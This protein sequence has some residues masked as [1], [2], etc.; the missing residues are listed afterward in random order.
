M[1]KQKLE[2]V[3]KDHGS[4]KK[5][6]NWLCLFHEDHNPSAWIYEKDGKA[7]LVCGVC[8]MI[9]DWNDVEDRLSGVKGE[10][11]K[12]QHKRSKEPVK[13]QR[14]YS[15]K[16]IEDGG[17]ATK[18]YSEDRKTTYC[19]T[20]RY[21]Q[22]K[23]ERR[24]AIFS[25]NGGGFIAQA[26]NP[27]PIL[28]LP[29][30]RNT[31]E[32]VICE[33]EKCVKALHKVGI[34]AT[35]KPCGGQAPEKADWTPVHGK[36]VILWPDYDAKGIGYMEQVKDLL[37]PHCR[38][39]WID[40]TKYNL[41]PK[42]D[43]YDYCVAIKWDKLK[44]QIPLT[45]AV[46]CGVSRGI[47][48]YVEDVISGKLYPVEWP[49]KQLTR[50]S[51]CLTPGS[52]TLF[53]GGGGAGKSM[54]LINAMMYWQEENIKWCLHALESPMKNHMLRALAIKTQNSEIPDMDWIIDNPEEIRGCLDEN[55]D[56]IDAF[57][58][59]ITVA[60]SRQTQTQIGKWI[61]EKAKCGHRIV[62]IDPISIVKADMGNNIWDA[63]DAFVE[64]LEKIA[65]EHG[66]SIVTVIHPTKDE[67]AP[68]LRAIKGGTAWPNFTHTVLWLEPIKE[69]ELV[70]LTSVGR[71]EYM[72][73][74]K[75]HLFKTREGR[76]WNISLGFWFDK[77][78]LKFTEHGMIVK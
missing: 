33:G 13:K 73:N 61:V 10:S 41:P 18:Y 16:E 66:I 36:E 19:I 44:A 78:T 69:K 32:V 43:A 68:S 14:I 30:V 70:C 52:T 4:F 25:P 75:L 49:W 57:G 21:E 5:N 59:N 15:L 71:T 7:R 46:D 77:N 31:K 67:G 20:V 1:S 51:R 56:W 76:E 37:L 8:G 62:V 45:E 58:R 22:G 50:L 35:T 40:P 24:F 47:S 74:R 9:G 27:L 11:F 29:S 17:E 12:K 2:Q 55:K 72:V 39:R 63:D 34:V 65:T 54:F 53:C 38:V 64:L 6:T 60:K 42:G 26:P 3:L 23:S 28:N 48:Q